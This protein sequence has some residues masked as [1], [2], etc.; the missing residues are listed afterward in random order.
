[1]WVG[2]FNGWG[3]KTPF[4]NNGARIKNTDVWLLKC[5]L[6][7][8]ARVD[9]KLVINGKDWILDP[10]NPQHQWSGVG[11]GAPNSELAMPGWKRDSYATSRTSAKH[12]AIQN[13]LVLQSKVLAYSIGYSIYTPVGMGKKKLPIL[14]VVDGNEYNHPKLANMQTVL[15]NLIEDKKIQPLIVVFIDSREPGNLQ[16]NRRMQ[17]LS[18]NEKYLSMVTDELIPSVEKNLPVRKDPGHRGILG[19]SL[20]GLTSAYFAFKRPDVFGLAGIQSAAFWYKPEIFTICENTKA[21]KV[22]V[23]MT[24]GTLYDA[25][26]TSQKMKGI[27]D[28]N[29]VAC[30]YRETREGHSW[31]AWRNLIDD[32]LIDLFAKR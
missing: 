26:E 15:D 8:D 21:S 17:E 29:S 27:F 14:Y 4:N 12:G 30:T 25:S 2:D 19:T 13:D 22:R 9:Y 28:K 20:G 5:S 7:A 18:L 3:S 24:A 16:N 31:G 23:S 1:M 32:M 11:G 10:D 6:P